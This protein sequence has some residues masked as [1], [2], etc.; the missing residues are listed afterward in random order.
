MCRSARHTAST[1]VASPAIVNLAALTH[2]WRADRRRID[3]TCKSSRRASLRGF[4]SGRR[5]LANR[6]PTRRA[7]VAPP[8]R[9][10]RRWGVRRKPGTRLRGSTRRCGRSGRGG[11]AR[12]GDRA[13]RRRQYVVG[14]ADDELAHVDHDVA[15]VAGELRLYEPVA[16]RDEREILREAFQGGRVAHVAHGDVEKE[17]A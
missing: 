15:G 10:S 11:G 17:L 4:R 7:A 2:P 12:C 3:L 1:K 13:G 14:Q 8:V 9:R 6:L 5:A 16:A